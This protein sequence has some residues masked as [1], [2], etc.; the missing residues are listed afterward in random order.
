MLHII[1]LRF[2]AECYIIHRTESALDWS[3][4]SVAP[5]CVATQ[6]IVAVPTHASSSHVHRQ[7]PSS[8]ESDSTETDSSHDE[9]A[10]HKLK[11]IEDKSDV[12][13]DGESG[14]VQMDG[15]QILVD[16]GQMG[17]SE[18]ERG[19]GMI[20][21]DETG[22]VG[23]DV[24]GL[25]VGGGDMGGDGDDDP[26]MG[27]GENID[28]GETHLSEPSLIPHG[29]NVGDSASWPGDVGYDQHMSDP[30]A[31]DQDGDA[32]ALW[33]SHGT[34][35][36]RTVADRGPHLQVPGFHRRPLNSH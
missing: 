22:G 16:G 5:P 19:D 13:V 24:M 2:L 33:Q 27:Y 32:R 35:H 26:G 11:S 9:D 36:Y 1:N 17:D 12:K 31:M 23:Y 25:G 20:G 15:Q 34:A 10:G 7:E 18:M 29:A 30:L 14:E 28:N 4:I 21:G 8:G 6:T 3:G